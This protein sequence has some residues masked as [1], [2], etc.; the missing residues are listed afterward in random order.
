MSKLQFQ[1]RKKREK[2]KEREQ[3]DT[4]STASTNGASVDVKDK[5]AQAEIASQNTNKTIQD[6]KKKLKEL[7]SK[8][9]STYHGKRRGRKIVT[10]EDEDVVIDDDTEQH[11]LYPSVVIEKDNSTNPKPKP[12]I[13]SKNSSSS[14]SSSSSSGSSSTDSE[15]SSESDPEKKKKK[16]EKK[17]NKEIAIPDGSAVKPEQDAKDDVLPKSPIKSDNVEPLQVS[18]SNIQLE[19]KENENENLAVPEIIP[20]TEPVSQK[21]FDMKNLNSWTEMAMIDTTSTSTTVNAPPPKNDTWSK[22]QNKDLQNKQRE[23]ERE[24]QEE[25]ERREKLERE[26]ER[27]RQEEKRIQDEKEIEEKKKQEEEE[28]KAAFQREIAEKRAAEKAAREQEALE[29][30]LRTTL[31]EQSLVMSTFER[32][33]IQTSQMFNYKKDDGEI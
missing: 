3:K 23:K 11:N 12:K 10:V 30:G 26:A 25:K 20:T 24:E 33:T 32:E 5:L 22:F 15:T 16:H 29:P 8:T 13:A 14:S 2:E 4:K 19:K 27:R 9:Q 7:D 6:V 31:L 18:N 17:H 1:N 21:E 28:A